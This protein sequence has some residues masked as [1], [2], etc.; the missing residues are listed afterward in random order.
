MALRLI[1]PLGVM[2]KLM[3]EE[4]VLVIAQ[5]WC[6]KLFRLTF[7]EMSAK[8]ME[9]E[10]IKTVFYTIKQLTDFVDLLAGDGGEEDQT[11]FGRF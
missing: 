5:G 7:R 2:P 6:F 10:A 9:I 8:M 1:L 4:E 11:A 3:R